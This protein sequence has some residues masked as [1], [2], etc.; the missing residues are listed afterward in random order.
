MCI[1]PLVPQVSEPCLQIG[2]LPTMLP[3]HLP[4]TPV[5]ICIFV[6]LAIFTALPPP[7]NG[8]GFSQALQHPTPPVHLQP[9]DEKDPSWG[10][11]SR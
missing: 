10:F 2:A 1:Q 9:W 3:M 4:G 11:I 5:S 7:C 6:L 8:A